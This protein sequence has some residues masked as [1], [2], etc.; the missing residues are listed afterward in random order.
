M[1]FVGLQ[2]MCGMSAFGDLSFSAHSTF[3]LKINEQ[4]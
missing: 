2:S 1:D 4:R 3:Y